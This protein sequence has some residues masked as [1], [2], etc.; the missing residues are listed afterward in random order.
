FYPL[1]LSKLAFFAPAWLLA[2]E[3]ISAVL[4]ARFTVVTVLLAPNLLGV[5]LIVLFPKLAVP[6]F[7]LVNLRLIAVPSNSMDFYYDFFFRNELT[8]FCQITFLKPFMN[9][10]YQDQLSV[11]MAKTYGLGSTNASLFATEGI[12][13]VGTLLAPLT[14]FAC[15]LVIALANRL[16]AGLPPRLILISGSVVV[17][18]L[19]NVPLTTTLLSHGAALL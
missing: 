12:A 17:Q 13:S 1:T 8:H 18:I 10:P 9:C 15:G 16:S 11:V 14:V 4:S 7:D 6:Y 5:I 2:I 3:A 19:L